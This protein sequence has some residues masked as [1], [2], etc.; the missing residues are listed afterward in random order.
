MSQYL[1][2]KEFT[3]KEIQNILRALC[4]GEEQIGLALLNYYARTDLVP[5][6]GKTLSRGR[7]KYTYS[8]LILLCWLFR[9]K[10]EGLPVNRFRKGLDYLREKLP[11]LRKNPQD[12]VL[13]TDGSNLFLKNRIDHK[14]EIAEALTGARSGQYVWVYAI[15]SLIKE[16]DSIVTNT[17]NLNTKLKESTLKKGTINNTSTNLLQSNTDQPSLTTPNEMVADRVGSGTR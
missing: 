15:G 9:M 4:G 17:S 10:R 3:A 6:S 11:R 13:L 14:D 2:D 8:D 7:T 16:V 1:V 5:S 12:M